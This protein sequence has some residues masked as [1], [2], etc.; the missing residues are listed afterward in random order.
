MQTAE[1]REKYGSLTQQSSKSAARLASL[2][3]DRG[4]MAEADRERRQH[5]ERHEAVLATLEQGMQEMN[6]RLEAEETQTDELR[7][8]LHKING[9]MLGCIKLMHDT[10]ERGGTAKEE[11]KEDE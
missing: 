7:K 4:T 3:R 8:E 1:L 6:A 5:I 9:T 11:P 10:A 2:E